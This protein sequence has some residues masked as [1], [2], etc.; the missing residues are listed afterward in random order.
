MVTEIMNG[1]DGH[2]FILLNENGRYYYF[3]LTF[4]QISNGQ[5]SLCMSHI[6][7]HLTFTPYH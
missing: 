6:W 5:V 1:M 2:K 7:Q 3:L 4:L